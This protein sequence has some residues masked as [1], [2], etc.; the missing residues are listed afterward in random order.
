MYYIRKL[1]KRTTLS[2]IKNTDNIHDIGA[3]I[4]KQ[5]L[6]TTNNTLSFWK[7]TNLENTKD[8]I[9]AILLSTTSIEAS[10]FIIVNDQLI[11]KYEIDIDDKVAG[12]T[13]YKDHEK[14]HVDFCNLTYRKIGNILELFKEIS[15]QTCLTRKLEKPEVKNYI[16]EVISDNMLDKSNIRPE[17]LKDIEK[18]FSSKMVAS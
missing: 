2:K 5:E 8:T 7:C 4:L 9:K 15:E 16:D 14:L 10:Q 1:S 11:K 17:L 3:D 12:N 6:S 13:G 18:Y